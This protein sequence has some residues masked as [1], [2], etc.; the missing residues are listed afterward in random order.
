[1]RYGG[2]VP[3]TVSVRTRVGTASG[4]GTRDGAADLGP[5]EME[6]LDA[7][8][9]HEAAEV[10]DDDVEGPGEIARHGRRRA[11]AAHVRAHDA[12]PVREPRHP[13]IPRGAALGIAVQQE[14]RPGR[15][16]GIGVVVNEV[17]QVEAGRNV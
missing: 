12:I 17:V 3:T 11:E 1:M 2:G 14:D 4:E 16:P 13:G 8:R 7:Q 9:I 10:V 6:A 15:A 5:D